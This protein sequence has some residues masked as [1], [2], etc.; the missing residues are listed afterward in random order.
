MR[1]LV[2]LR[3]AGG[4]EAEGLR[5]MRLLGMDTCYLA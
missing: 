5:G 1:V 3:S 2:A 4:L